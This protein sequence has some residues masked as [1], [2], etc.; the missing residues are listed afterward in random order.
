MSETLNQ[1]K[2]RGKSII[3]KMHRIEDGV[4]CGVTLLK[5]IS[6]EYNR[7]DN[8]LA[9]VLKAC[10]AIDKSCPVESMSERQALRAQNA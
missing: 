4:T 3:L 2:A 7:L 1:L 6:P 9:D 5:H 8:E 10:A